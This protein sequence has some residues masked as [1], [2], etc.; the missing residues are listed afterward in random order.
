MLS[1]DGLPKYPMDPDE[2][3]GWPSPCV[4]PSCSS[5]SRRIHFSKCSVCALM[6]DWTHSTWDG[7]TEDLET[8]WWTP[9]KWDR[10]LFPLANPFLADPTT[11][12]QDL[13]IPWQSQPQGGRGRLGEGSG[14]SRPENRFQ[15]EKDGTN[16]H[17]LCQAHFREF[18][19]RFQG[20]IP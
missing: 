6:D 9:R 16:M 11:C 5:C 17:K 15:Q 18:H 20:S 10:Q 14:P 19:L 2:Q 1:S 4:C 13:R 12:C 3:V 7:F 8:S